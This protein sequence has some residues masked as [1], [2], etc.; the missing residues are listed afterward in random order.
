MKQWKMEAPWNATFIGPDGAEGC[1]VGQHLVPGGTRPMLINGGWVHPVQVTARSGGHV[2]LH[3]LGVAVV[4][5]PHAGGKGLV[6]VDVSWSGEG[7]PHLRLGRD[8]D[9]LGLSD[10]LHLEPRPE[11]TLLMEIDV[12]S[13]CAIFEVA[14]LGAS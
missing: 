5:V 12:K 14:L 1:M 13:L 7:S 3:T 4:R 6:K 9:N 10:G 2:V 8:V 11:L